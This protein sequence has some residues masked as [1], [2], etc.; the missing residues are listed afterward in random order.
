MITQHINMTTGYMMP[1]LTL[2]EFVE[3]TA[4]LHED[5]RVKVSYLSGGQLDPAT[6]E[7]TIS[8]SADE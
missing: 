7:F 1:L 4:H 6:V 2:R 3:A 8:L 5:I